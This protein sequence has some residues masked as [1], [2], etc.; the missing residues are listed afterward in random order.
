MPS[1]GA[2]NNMN[3]KIMNKSKL[4][5]SRNQDRNLEFLGRGQTQLQVNDALAAKNILL[6]TTTSNDVMNES[7]HTT[8]YRAQMINPTANNKMLANQRRICF[9]LDQE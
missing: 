1:P 5:P 9:D 4:E 6:K 8:V 7:I 2:F 3:K